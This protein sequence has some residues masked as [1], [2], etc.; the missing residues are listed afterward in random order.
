MSMPTCYSIFRYWENKGITEKG[1]VCDNG[2]LPVVA[3]EH[4]PQCWA[5]GM[6]VNKRE[7]LS[8]DKYDRSVD[9]T[10]KDPRVNNRLNRCHIVA[11]QFGGPDDPENLFLLCE[12]CHCESPDTTNRAAFFRW[13]YRRRKEYSYG[14]PL[15]KILREMIAEIKVRGYDPIWFA[16]KLRSYTGDEMDTGVKEALTR[17]GVHGTAIADSSVVVCVVDELERMVNRVVESE[18]AA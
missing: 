14:M 7:I 1:E 18:E 9:E 16:N 6:P 17:C 8:W 11:K 12:E 5:C 15:K 4:L 13:V 10:W 3:N 2:G